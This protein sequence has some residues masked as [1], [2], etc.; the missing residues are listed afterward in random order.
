MA[1]YSQEEA[2]KMFKVIPTTLKEVL[3]S[4]DTAETILK[5]TQEYNINDER[6]RKLA[7]LVGYSL[8]GML[9]P[10]N[11]DK[12]IETELNIDKETAQE[13]AQKI[14][15]L[16]LYQVKDELKDLYQ[17]IQIYPSGAVEA[18]KETKTKTEEPEEKQ[19]IS[20]KTDIYR[21]PIDEEES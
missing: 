18:E 8:L 1:K 19:K 6:V 10:S 15:R 2:R 21:E 12:E 9:P 5:I 3:L 20:S 7:S 14:I 13:I 17:N 4:P 11:L 16:I